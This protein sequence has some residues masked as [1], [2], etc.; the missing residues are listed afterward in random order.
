MRKSL[1]I[2]SLALAATGVA[3]ARSL[4]PS[5]A[6]ARAL[7]TEGTTAAK[8][9]VRKM[10]LM[11]VG[12]EEIPALYVFDRG[13]QGFMLVSAD[14]VAAPVLGYSDSGVFDPENIPADVQWWLDQYKSQIEN[15]VREGLPAYSAPS[16]GSREPIAPLMKTLWNQDQPYNAQS[17]NYPTQ[18]PMECVTG[19]V[20]TAM[21]QVM[22]YHEW[23]ASIN[24]DFTYTWR[25]TGLPLNWKQSNVTFDW[26]NMLNTYTTGQYNSVQAT[27]VATL[28][29]ACGYS[30]DMNYGPALYG[31]SGAN[32]F[33]MNKAFTSV[34]GYDKGMYAVNRMFFS[35]A[36]WEYQI[37]SNLTSCGPVILTGA[38][39]DAG[40]CFVCDGYR[41]GGYF[42][43]NWG[44]GG[45]SDGY[46]LLSALNPDA[47]GIGGSS[48]GFN[49]NLYA[50]LG[51]KKPVADASYPA[52]IVCEGE[53]VPDIT[54]GTLSLLGYFMNLSARDLVG[55]FGI[56]FT[57][58]H[59]EV[60]KDVFSTK[61]ISLP[62]STYYTGISVQASFI[63]SGTSRLYPVFEES[64]TGEITVIPTYASISDYIIAEKNGSNVKFTTPEVGVFSCENV[65]VETPLFVDCGFMVK[66]KAKWSGDMSV[67][68]TVVGVFMT[69]PSAENFVYNGDAMVIEFPAN[70]EAVDFEYV[71]S[72]I[73]Y[74]DTYPAKAGEYYFAMAV[75][76]NAGAN[77]IRL[78]SEPVPVYVDSNPGA[79]SISVG[80]L[81]VKDPNNVD[82]NDVVVSVPIQ[83][84]GGYFFNRLTVA[85]LSFKTNGLY[86]TF[87]SPIAVIGAG[88]MQTITATG[89]IPGAVKGERYQI[90]LFL[91]STYLNVWK[92]IIIGNT[93]G[94]ADIAADGVTGVSASP[95]PATD[96][97]VITSSAEIS[98][99][100][101]AALSGSLVS[102]PVEIDGTTARVDVSALAP[103]LYI[104][105]VATA[106]GVESVKIIKK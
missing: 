104:A 16:R 64:A 71:S 101:I 70:G 59:G 84:T 97:T 34:F 19:C 45:A 4:S 102:V 76:D 23:P 38:N 11:T 5:E 100:D 68:N 51:I 105:R 14:D 54:M 77:G 9:P 1:L 25:N 55:K 53:M 41:D 87:E 89:V 22:K 82:P 18:P 81:T 86:T 44:W 32:G 46:Y 8:A 103:G 96:Y 10:P 61:A 67:S 6:L 40:H 26:A 99:V 106:A 83:C 73:W 20:A 21:A 66:G 78:I 47:Q 13:E 92:D 91:G 94:I 63:P 88:E 48:D 28:M 37:Y 52:R 3:E 15:A 57:D 27:A 90:Q 85:V 7:S 30:V 65:T 31:G 79:P 35:L 2:L 58:E 98:R 62:S 69:A 43:I 17:P 75:E 72:D 95:N 33:A 42:H 56:R 12:S 74:D 80:A 24:A 29:K 49:I 60:I 50:Y 39:N 36:D 93:S